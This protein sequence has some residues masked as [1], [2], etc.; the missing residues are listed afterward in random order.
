MFKNLFKIKFTS[1]LFI[2]VISLSIIT[3]SVIS[4]ISLM[5]SK[6]G[7]KDMGK[8]SIENTAK[9][10]YN[11]IVI[12]HDLLKEK[13]L[14][15]IQI[16]EQI[17]NSKGGVYL[18]I[19]DT[20]TI[21]VTDQIS[22][23]KTKAE[24]PHIYVGENKLY[25]TTELVDTIRKMTN[26]MVTV[27]QY[28]EDKLIRVSTTVENGNDR[29]TDT[30]INRDS[31]VY[32]SVM[33][34]ETYIGK[35][36]V[37]DD[38]YMTIYTPVKDRDGR[39]IS[40]L[41]LGKKILNEQLIQM[42]FETKAAEVGYFFIYNDKGNLLIHPTLK[43]KNLFEIPVIGD[44]FKHHK[45]GFLDYW[46]DNDHK[47]SHISYFAPW[48]WYI[49]VGLSETQMLRGVDITIIKYVS[50]ASVLLL[51]FG[52]LFSY[53]LVKVISLPLKDLA[54]KSTIMSTGDYTVS[55]NYDIDDDI[56]KL[57]KAMS[58]MVEKTRST[59]NNVISATHTLSSASTELA[60]VATQM[61]NSTKDAAKVAMN[62]NNSSKEVSVH[63]S[64]IS[65]AMEEASINVSTVAAAAEEMSVT[66]TE[67]AQNAEKAKYVS[68]TAVE[69]TN[70]TSEN[71]DKLVAAMKEITSITNSIAAISSQ[72]NLL[73]L[74]ATIEAARAGSHG[75]GFAVV[76]NEIKD[77]ANQAAKATEDIKHK[78]QSIQDI[79]DVSVKD[80]VTVTSIIY[81]INDGMNTIATAVEE[82]SVT[83]RDIAENV[84]QV[85]TGINEINQSVLGSVTM[86]NGIS[87]S[88]DT[89]KT[90]TND[91]SDS[92]GHVQHS[93]NELSEI[94]EKL[95]SMV[96]YFK[97]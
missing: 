95:K 38:W 14:T 89:V 72:T 12:Q 54:N 5:V 33:N 58:F 81:E 93:A 84:N 64:T 27:F 32:K 25:K 49:G 2:G 83:T 22:G 23:V 7:I 30:Y 20:H 31:P 82:Q 45:G 85:S 34:G 21:E 9:A 74:N 65:A 70:Q 11:S 66:I 63:L 86:V 78:I 76:A 90:T 10:V 79:T 43:G 91:I 36:F 53:I 75:K 51:V 41:F 77:L 18:D 40:V 69:T 68:N 39:I 73:A 13:L 60:E 92:S 61:T 4:S 15:D 29:A 24:L 35:A 17:V 47:I 57:N 80:M 42:V 55:F 71:I 59:L 96:S 56:G 8:S 1:K 6:D 48:D 50:F 94:A 87:K 16:L 28:H 67:I 52:L 19:H 62:V 88:M 26:S 46:W 3:I 44:I 37:V 97:L